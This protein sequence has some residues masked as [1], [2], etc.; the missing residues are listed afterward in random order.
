M[1]PDKAELKRIGNVTSS[2]IREE[3]S[4]TALTRIGSVTSSFVLEGVLQT[5]LTRIG[6]IHCAFSKVKEIPPSAFYLEIS[7]ETIWLVPWALNDVLS[8]TSWNI[9]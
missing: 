9:Q 3:V 8:N 2:F 6:D 7:P 4:Q 1:I 5:A